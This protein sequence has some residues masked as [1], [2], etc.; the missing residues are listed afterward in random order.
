MDRAYLD[1]E[2]A[3]DGRITVV[4]I[5][6]PDRGTIQLVG[7]DAT[8]AAIMAFLDGSSCLLT[9]NGHRFDLPRI[10][11]EL[12]LD[13]RAL[14][15]CRDLMFDCWRL[16]LKGGFKKVEE[17]LGVGRG[18][19]GVDGMMAM[20]LWE[21]YVDL[22][23]AE[24]LALLLAYNRD[25]CENMPK[26]LERLEALGLPAWTGDPD[27]GGEQPGGEQPREGEARNKEERRRKRR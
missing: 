1:I 14:F 12:S 9:Y 15:P 3:F 25:D 2:T 22:D 21:K 10:K 16:G 20:R 24:A 8:P 18:T 5:H 17:R 27:H 26:V 6:R 11:D 4:G 19:A 23:D 13:L 7:R